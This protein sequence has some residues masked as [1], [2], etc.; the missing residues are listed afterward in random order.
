M[1][2]CSQ[3]RIAEL[4]ARIAELEKENEKLKEKTEEYE[5]VEC[6]IMETGRSSQNDF[7]DI[8]LHAHYREGKVIDG[9]WVNDED[10][11]C[12]LANISAGSCSPAFRSS[13]MGRVRS[14]VRPL[15]FLAPLA[16]PEAGP[17]PG[18]AWPIAMRSIQTDR[19]RPDGLLAAPGPQTAV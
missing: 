10:S 1:M 5:A 9:E 7:F 17:R 18:R 15:R 11:N 13:T 4:E 3:T 14:K 16:G 6:F 12:P 8:A 2:T 19:R